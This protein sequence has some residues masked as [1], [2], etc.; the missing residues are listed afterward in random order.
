MT[1]T[2]TASHHAAVAAAAQLAA[3]GLDQQSI[4][5]RLGG[6]SQTSVSRLLH[7]AE[8]KPEKVWPRGCHAGRSIAQAR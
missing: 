5:K 8:H 1:K 6:I 7:A 4:A 2:R 3:Q